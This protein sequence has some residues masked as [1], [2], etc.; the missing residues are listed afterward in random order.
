MANFRQ[1][2]YEKPDIATMEKFSK[3]KFIFQLVI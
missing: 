3:F 2:L 1:Q